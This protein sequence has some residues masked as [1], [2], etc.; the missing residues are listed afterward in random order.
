M[1]DRIGVIFHKNWEEF[2]PLVYV[3]NGGK[4]IP[5]CIQD[6]LKEYYIQYDIKNNSNGYEY[7]PNHMLVGFL[8]SLE[9][10]KQIRTEN[11]TDL[12]L[13]ILIKEQ[14][15]PNCFDGGCWIVD[16]SRYNYGET[17]IDGEGY[18]ILDNDNI[19]SDELKNAY[20]Y[21]GEM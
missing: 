14:S 15:Y 19:F 17:V 9:K 2:S 18:Y 20:D 21:Y 10:D 16:V 13:D 6:F 8:Q 4:Y 7:N 3:N 11:L 12:N 1:S 5:Y